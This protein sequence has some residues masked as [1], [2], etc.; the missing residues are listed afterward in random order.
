MK[1][2][3]KVFLSETSINFIKNYLIEEM[4]ITKPIDEEKLA[5]IEDVCNDYGDLLA[6]KEINPEIVINEEKCL[7]ADKVGSEIYSAIE[8]SIIDYNDL[9]KKLGLI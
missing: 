9:N 5:E 4:N 3:D 1:N 7:L 8:N 2:K 6:S